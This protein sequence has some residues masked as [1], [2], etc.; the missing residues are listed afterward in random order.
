MLSSA[1]GTHYYM[2]CSER[3]YYVRRQL[4]EESDALSALVLSHQR[5]WAIS[6]HVT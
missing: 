5:R 4:L 3:L 2:R 6:A 1:H